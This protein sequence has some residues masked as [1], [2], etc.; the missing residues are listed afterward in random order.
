MGKLENEND[1]GEWRRSR[2]RPKNP[3]RM[4]ASNQQS[5]TGGGR[6]R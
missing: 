4:E 3:S 2:R 6:G 1:D 5:E